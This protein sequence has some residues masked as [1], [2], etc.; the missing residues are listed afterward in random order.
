MKGY[1]LAGA[2]AI[3][4][5]LLVFSHVETYRAGKAVAQAAIVARLIKENTNAGNVAE[6]WRATLRRCNGAGGMFDFE[7]GSCDR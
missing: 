2:A 3:A 1:L 7:A 4:A 6:D 5:G